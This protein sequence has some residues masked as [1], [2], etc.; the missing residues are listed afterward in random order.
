[1]DLSQDLSIDGSASVSRTVRYD[2]FRKRKKVKDEDTGIA[3][4]SYDVTP[5]AMHHSDADSSTV[6]ADEG[7][8]VQPFNAAKTAAVLGVGSFVAYLIT[9]AC[10]GACITAETN[11]ASATVSAA[12]IGAYAAFGTGSLAAVV[13]CFKV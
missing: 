9:G 3:W 5:E 11:P 2:D 4:R 8:T 13:A 10:G 12:C 7:I 1:V 6:D